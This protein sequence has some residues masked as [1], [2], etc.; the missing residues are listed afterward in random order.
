[1]I[2][3]RHL[4]DPLPEPLDRVYGGADVRQA[5]WYRTIFRHPE[6]PPG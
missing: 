4:R 6:P 3:R 5:H 1:V 2:S